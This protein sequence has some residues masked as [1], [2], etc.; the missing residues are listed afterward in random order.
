MAYNRAKPRIEPGKTYT[1]RNWGKL[2][3]GPE[4][5]VVLRDDLSD[6]EIAR[7]LGRSLTAIRGR[8]WLVR[9]DPKWAAVVGMSD[10]ADGAA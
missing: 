4:M 2:W 5:E 8:R 3:T 10:R 9:N 6:K 1:G 7:I